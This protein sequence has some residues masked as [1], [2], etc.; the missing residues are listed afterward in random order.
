VD[1]RS[2]N[3]F[4]REKE[5]MN[6]LVSI[7]S[8]AL[9]LNS[10]DPGTLNQPVRHGWS[11]N[12]L[13][14]ASHHGTLKQPIGHGWSENLL[15]TT[16]NQPTLMQ[17]IGHEWSENILPFA[18]AD[19]LHK[20]ALMRPPLETAPSVDRPFAETMN[21]LPHQQQVAF[22]PPAAPA[23]DVS[24]R[25]SFVGLQEWEGVV[26]EIRDRAFTARLMDLTYPK[27]DEEGEFCTDEISEDD[28]NLVVPGAIFRWSVG[29]LKMPG[30]AKRPTSQ[31]VF[32]RLPQWTKRDLERADGVAKE[33]LNAFDTMKTPDSD[34]ARSTR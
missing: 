15:L 17:P 26:T 11:E 27:P 19:E 12:F 10:S 29:V 3:G 5:K 23:V 25:P 21:L 4:E 22:L 1:Y 9:H 14:T 33:L 18:V 16:S 34:E 24:K 31:I 6:S 7:N 28:L 20:A 13:V 32:R 2:G 30:G 8:T